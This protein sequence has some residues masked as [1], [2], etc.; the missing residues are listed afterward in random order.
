[1]NHSSSS[2]ILLIAKIKEII[3]KMSWPTNNLLTVF[4][5]SYDCFVITLFFTLKQ[6][7]EEDHSYLQAALW[8]N[9]VKKGRR[10]TVT[11]SC[12]YNWFDLCSKSIRVEGKNRNNV[13]FVNLFKVM[14]SRIPSTV[15]YCVLYSNSSTITVAHANT[16]TTP[17]LLSV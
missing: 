15:T 12:T 17:L 8:R 16:T 10:N 14:C 13:V 4:V 2:V 9:R 7:Y 5:A 11:Y 6:W 3:I 1:M